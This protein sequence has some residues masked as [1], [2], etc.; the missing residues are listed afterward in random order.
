MSNDILLGFV[1]GLIFV[2]VLAVLIMMASGDA[3]GDIAESC[4]NNGVFIVADDVYQC[5]LVRPA[6]QRG[7]M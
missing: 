7:V 2:F 4:A 3:I 5:R 1:A 6:Q